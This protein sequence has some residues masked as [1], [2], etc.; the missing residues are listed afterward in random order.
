MILL[1]T[2]DA[3]ELSYEH[4]AISEIAPIKLKT[5]LK[6]IRLFD[7]TVLKDA[8]IATLA[9]PLSLLSLNC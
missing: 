3:A 7:A 4:A 1:K 2:L 8:A 6:S 9:K 5:L